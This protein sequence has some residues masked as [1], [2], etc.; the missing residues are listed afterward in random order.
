[1]DTFAETAIVDYRLS[2][3]D[4]VKQTSDFRFRL[5]QTKGSLAFLFFHLQKL[6]FSVS[7]VLVCSRMSTEL[8]FWNCAEVRIVSE[9]IFTSAEFHGIPFAKFPEY[10]GI[11]GRKQHGIPKEI[12]ELL[13]FGDMELRKM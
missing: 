1:M 9:L 11:P 7:S 2:F 6:P 10:R 12:Q 8:D 3:V 4:L 13:Y 5:R